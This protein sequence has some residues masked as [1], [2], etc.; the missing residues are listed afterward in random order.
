MLILPYLFALTAD[1]WRLG[2]TE[3]SA[4]LALSKTSTR[5][6]NV[7]QLEWNKETGSRQYAEEAHTHTEKV[8]EELRVA[9]TH[10][11]DTPFPIKKDYFSL[12]RDLPH[13]GSP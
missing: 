5:Q 7:G 1:D 3:H 9:K 6:S 4:H 2:Y 12:S 10:T 8:S 13:S 11:R